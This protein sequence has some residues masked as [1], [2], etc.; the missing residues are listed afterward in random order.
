[1]P[2]LLHSRRDADPGRDPRQHRDRHRPGP[3]HP[4]A[5]GKGRG[6]ATPNTAPNTT[7]NTTGAGQL[8]RYV[9]AMSDSENKRDRA[10]NAMAG[11]GPKMRGYFGLGVE[12][13]SKPM[14]L[15]AVLRT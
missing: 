3:R 12:G 2:R 5:E 1:H 9:S 6:K 15:G 11:P 10:S 4:P 8:A 13:I 7:P 14:N